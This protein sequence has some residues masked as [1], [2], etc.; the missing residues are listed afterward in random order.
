[1][2]RHDAGTHTGTGVLHC[3]GLGHSEIQ[4]SPYLRQAL[5]R[6]LGLV[7]TR[8]RTAIV[9]LRC[10]GCRVV[11]DWVTFVGLALDLG[12]RV[13]HVTACSFSHRPGPLSYLLMVLFAVISAD[14]HFRMSAACCLLATS[15]SLLRF[16]RWLF[17]LNDQFQVI[18]RVLSSSF[19]FFFRQSNSFSS[20]NLGFRRLLFKLASTTGLLLCTV[21]SAE[22][23]HVHLGN[24]SPVPKGCARCRVHHYSRVSGP[25]CAHSG[26]WRQEREREALA[27]FRRET[28]ERIS[29]GEGKD[30][31]HLV[32]R[33]PAHVALYRSFKH[34]GDASGYPAWRETAGRSCDAYEA[35][36]VFESCM[37][38][39]V[40]LSGKVGLC[41]PRRRA[42]VQ[43]GSAWNRWARD[44]PSHEG[45]PPAGHCSLWDGTVG[46]FNEA[47]S[48]CLPRAAGC[49]ELRCWQAGSESS[50]RFGTVSAC[51]KPHAGVARRGSATTRMPLVCRQVLDVDGCHGHC[52]PLRASTTPF[53]HHN[54]RPCF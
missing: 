35:V 8:G 17:I 13:A 18:F 52:V 32:A 7:P 45:H 48:G 24:E 20:F 25:G 12:G 37:H 14:C 47:W 51:C 30:L 38:C 44:V 3:A 42:G 11:L 26:G 41:Y 53:S 46:P 6:L 2:P 29:W 15:L 39:F 40:D 10:G 21:V 16:Y 54:R 31:G 34:R 1:M 36:R 49:F 50:G 33:G 5:F 19:V 43:E 23:R 9:A 27:T 22:G 28:C 4:V